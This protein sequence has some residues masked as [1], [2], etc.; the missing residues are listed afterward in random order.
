[1]GHTYASRYRLR[2]FP[3]SANTGSRIGIT[4][5][6]TL[7]SVIR[8]LRETP[9]I[10]LKFPKLDINALKI[11]FYTDASYTINADLSSQLRYIVMLIDASH[12]AAVLHYQSSKSLR[13]AR[14]SIASETLAFSHGFDA[15]FLLRHEL[16]QMLGRVLPL[17]MMTDS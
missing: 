17:V 2:R 3:S 5:I 16:E 1:M 4:H 6:K 9:G 15:A 7:N 8:H 12:K 10:E 11:A 13:A 14:S